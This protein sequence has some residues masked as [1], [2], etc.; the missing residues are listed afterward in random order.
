MDIDLWW[1]SL[2]LL[3]FILGWWAARIDVQDIKRAARSLPKSYFQGLGFLLSEQPDKAIDAFGEV[4]RIDSEA[5]E[6]KF[7]LGSLFR[8]RGELDRAIRI[9]SE[10]L[11]HLGLPN[12]QREQALFELAQDYVRAGLLDRAEKCL[13]QLSKHLH[14]GVRVQVF[15]LDIYQ[16]E[17]NWT[18]TIEAAKTL[19]KESGIPRQKEIAQ[20]YCEQACYFQSQSR[21]DKAKE[22][23]LESLVV[24][25][26]SIRANI[27]LGDLDFQAEAYV[28]SIGHWQNIESQDPRYL[29][30]VAPRL[31]DA[32]RT[33]GKIEEGVVLIES[34]QQRYPSIDLF[35]ILFSTMRG[36]G[37]TNQVSK[38]VWEELQHR[39]SLIVVEKCLE[40]KIMTSQDLS[41]KDEWEKLRDVIHREAWDW[42]RY[43]CEEC[44]L[45]T[46]EFFWHCPGCAGWETC[47]PT[48]TEQLSLIGFPTSNTARPRSLSGL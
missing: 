21:L 10:I 16:M 24:N 35:G 27:I 34:Y 18:K 17:K 20:F 26:K 28:E 25:R 48:K 7:V 3:V 9:H 15:L 36:L 5:V 32:Y 42:T 41:D 29:G 33:I 39:S 12:L 4:A 14:Y 43:I 2:L 22:S 30:L 45:S 19:E 8:R 38:L 31:L 47:S 44:G 40:L 1:I 11:Q 37:K 46:K 6:I 23:A 13:D